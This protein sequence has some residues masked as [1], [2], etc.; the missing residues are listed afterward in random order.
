MAK[1]FHSSPHASYLRPRGASMVDV[2]HPS[3]LNVLLV[4]DDKISLTLCDRLLKQAK[5]RGTQRSKRGG[6]SG[7]RGW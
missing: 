5:Y 3:K 2:F 1:L 4:D 6:V 7:R